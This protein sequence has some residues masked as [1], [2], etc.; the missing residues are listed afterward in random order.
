MMAADLLQTIGAEK[1]GLIW[2]MAIV[3]HETCHAV[4]AHEGRPPGFDHE[5][6][7]YNEDHR[8]MRAL[9]QFE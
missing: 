5:D 4:Q 3:V 2:T 8:I 1:H 7:C 9:V 6:E